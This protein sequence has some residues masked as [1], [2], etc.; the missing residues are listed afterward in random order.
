MDLSIL[1]LNHEIISRPLL[2]GAVIFLAHWFP[3]VLVP[4]VPLVLAK[5]K[6]FSWKT[7]GMIFLPAVIAYTL[8]E[9][10]KFIFPA[11]RPF[12]DLLFTP[13]ITVS[14]PLG[15]FPSSHAA[16]FA[17]LSGGMYAQGRS[18]GIWFVLAALAIGAA[19]V[20]AGVHWPIDVLFGLF[21]GFFVGFF[22]LFVSSFRHIRRRF[23]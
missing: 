11:P 13:L 8:A 15:S 2:G 5:S 20:V 12:V 7:L 22:P 9:S 14:D 4:A 3:Y 6:K 10:I 19:R 18:L 1:Q 16:F 17:A 21:I 23:G